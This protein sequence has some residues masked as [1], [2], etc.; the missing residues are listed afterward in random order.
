LNAVM[1]NVRTG[2]NADSGPNR[3][4]RVLGVFPSLRAAR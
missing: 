3:G 2:F 1:R 4:E